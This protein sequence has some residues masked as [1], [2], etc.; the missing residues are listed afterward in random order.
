MLE[1]M[2][3]SSSDCC[4]FGTDTT[5]TNAWAAGEEG[6]PLLTAVKKCTGPQIG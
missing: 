2:N 4:T 6:T 3:A 1:A 5:L